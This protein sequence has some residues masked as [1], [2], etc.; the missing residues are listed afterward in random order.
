MERHCYTPK[1]ISFIKRHVAGRSYIELTDLFNKQHF[2]EPVT[3]A[4]M[5]GFIDN[6]KLRRR[7]DGR[8]K[9]GHIAWN[10]GMK[11]FRIPGGEKGWFK[12][13]HKLR[14]KYAVGDERVADGYVQVRVSNRKDKPWKRWKAKN[15]VLWEQAHG[16]VPKGHVVIFADGDNRNFSPDNLRLI[17]RA[18]NVVMNKF[19]LRSPNANLT[20]A[21]ILVTDIKMAVADRKRG[22][23]KRRNR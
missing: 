10:K 21:G 12:K 5:T 20:D 19:G 9:P 3:P 16:K 18:E 4:Q 8:F 2:G 17:S 6:H 1:E 14:V 23:L 7:R 11:G 15:V 13:G 22:L